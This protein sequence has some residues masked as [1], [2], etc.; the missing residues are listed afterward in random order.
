MTLLIGKTGCRYV[1]T[2]TSPYPGYA[3]V[4]PHPT[5]VEEQVR[6]NFMGPALSQEEHLRDAIAWRDETYRQLHGGKPPQRVFHRQQL[7]SNTTFP[8]VSR[9][10]KIVKKKRRDGTVAEYQVPCIIASICA[11]PGDNYKRSRGY[12]SKVYSINKYG[13]DEAIR[14]A[15]LWREHMIEELAGVS[16]A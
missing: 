16:S 5:N 15:V 14:L 11:V 4:I 13:E 10:V 9:N 12:K 1:T 7:N 3:V 8:G 6:K 2:I